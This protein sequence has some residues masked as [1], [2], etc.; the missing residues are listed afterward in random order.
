MIPL[1]S[2]FGVQA[3]FCVADWVASHLLAWRAYQVATPEQRRDPEPLLARMQATRRGG[4]GSSPYTSG[5]ATESE[6]TA[7]STDKTKRGKAIRKLGATRAWTLARARTTQKRKRH[8]KKKKA[9]TKAR[10]QA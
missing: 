4:G 8:H 9:T 1:I 10:K 3:A 2:V 7:M 5:C 6:E